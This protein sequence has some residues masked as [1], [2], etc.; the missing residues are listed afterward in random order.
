MIHESSSKP[1]SLHQKFS[2][3]GSS[4]EYFTLENVLIES[5]QEEAVERLS[6]KES[7]EKL[8][9]LEKN[10]IILRYFK[11]KTQKETGTELNL[12]QIQVSRL[13][14]KVLQKLRICLM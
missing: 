11:E 8:P 2:R 7:L 10:L 4:E 12:T 9:V 5:D 6:L 14:R 3:L 1:L 13:E